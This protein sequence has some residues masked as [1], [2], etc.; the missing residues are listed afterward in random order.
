MKLP[1]WLRSGIIFLVGLPLI[2]LAP[3]GFCFHLDGTACLEG[4]SCC[5]EHGDPVEGCDTCQDLI[6]EDSSLLHSGSRDASQ[7]TLLL[8]VA[9]VTGYASTVPLLP[10][11]IVHRAADA[12]ERGSGTPAIAQ[13]LLC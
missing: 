2:L 10:P 7:A 6:P 3:V 4:R 13:P 5:E 8:P 12:Q 9:V 11:L 1:R